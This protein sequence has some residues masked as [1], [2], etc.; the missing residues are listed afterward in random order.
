MGSQS[1]DKGRR[2]EREAKAMLA[3][4]GYTIL[5]DTSAG[6]STDDLVVM[7]QAGKVY[8]VEVKNTKLINLPV[9]LAQARG[10]AKKNAWMLL[11]K[12]DRQ[13]AWLVLGKD[14]PA[15]VW[16]TQEAQQ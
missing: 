4:R 6:L 7:D 5:A 8:S 1:R 9:F 12:L 2:G 15:T 11:C 16:H 3:D 14:R 13:G 10:N